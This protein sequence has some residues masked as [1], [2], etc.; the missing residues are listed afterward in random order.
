MVFA[1]GLVPCGGDFPEP[2]CDFN[3]LVSFANGIIAFAIKIAFYLAAIAFV[4]VGWLFMTSGG[5]PGKRE[6]AIKVLWKVFWGFVMILAAWLIV[7]LVLRMLG[8]KGEGLQFI[9]DIIR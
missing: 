6:E 4:W 1:K 9:E 7:S 8:Y 3:A 2:E 5:N